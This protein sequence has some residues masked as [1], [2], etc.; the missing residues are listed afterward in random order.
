VIRHAIRQLAIQTLYQMEV[1]KLSREEAIENIE[2]MVESLKED[3]IELVAEEITPQQAMQLDS[4][5][6]LDEFYFNLVDGVLTHQEAL[7]KLITENLEGW[8]LNRLNKVDKAIIR[9]A[10]YEM[11]FDKEIPHKVII[12]EAIELTR[13][14]SEGEDGKARGFNNKVLDQISKAITE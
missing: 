4:E 9:L 13:E 12:N 8:S 1:G 6:K 14:F 7:D 11:S 3:A 5:F 10:T 2:F